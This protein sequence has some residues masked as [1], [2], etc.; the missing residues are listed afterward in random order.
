MYTPLKTHENNS[1]DLI[2]IIAPF[3]HSASDMEEETKN[4]IYK[5]CIVDLYILCVHENKK[6]IKRIKVLFFFLKYQNFKNL[7]F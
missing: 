6:N 7:C 3:P 1:L 5:K 2:L 4:T